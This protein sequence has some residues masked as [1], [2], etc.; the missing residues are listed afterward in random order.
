MSNYV[1]E[2]KYRVISSSGVGSLMLCQSEVRSD[3]PFTACL[4]VY[5]PA[6]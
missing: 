4:C 5:R 2:Y 3:T 1:S 6:L